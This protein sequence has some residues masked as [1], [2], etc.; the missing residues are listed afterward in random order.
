VRRMSSYIRI[1][2]IVISFPLRDQ[3]S[4]SRRALIQS[5]G[6]SHGE[7]LRRRNFQAHFESIARSELGRWAATDF[8]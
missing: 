1:V 6:F 3:V 7:I 2:L 5:L 8:P 4:C